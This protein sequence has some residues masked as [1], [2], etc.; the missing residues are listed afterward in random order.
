MSPKVTV[1]E[2]GIVVA[3]VI[4]GVLFLT[5]SSALLGVLLCVAAVV[6]GIVLW[7]PLRE[8]LHIP[9]SPRRSLWRPTR[10]PQDRDRNGRPGR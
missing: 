1:D 8:R 7:T 4:A 10:P 6:I 3:L 9:P 5:G 2:L